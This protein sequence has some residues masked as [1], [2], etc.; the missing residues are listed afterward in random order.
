MHARL[1]ARDLVLAHIDAEHRA[2]G[3]DGATDL[4]QQQTA[5]TPDLDDPLAWYRRERLEDA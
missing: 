2:V 5:T 3:V 4:E 1:A